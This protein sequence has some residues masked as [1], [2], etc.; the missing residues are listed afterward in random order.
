MCSS[1]VDCAIE[2]FSGKRAK[3]LVRLVE[4]SSSS[5]FKDMEKERM[6]MKTSGLHPSN[7]VK[8]QQEKQS[9]EGRFQGRKLLCAVRKARPL[10]PSRGLAK[11]FKV[12]FNTSDEGAFGRPSPFHVLSTYS[13]LKM[14]VL[15]APEK[16]LHY[17]FR[18]YAVPVLM[19]GGNIIITF[20]CLWY[21]KG[22]D[23]GPF[24]PCV[25][26]GNAFA[27]KFVGI[28]FI[29]CFLWMYIG[30]KVYGP[31]TDYGQIPEY[32]GG[33]FRFY[34]ITTASY[35][36]LHIPY[37]KLSWWFYENF[38]Q[39]VAASHWCGL[40]IAVLLFIKGK[41][42]RD[43]DEKIAPYPLIHEFYRGIELHP[44]I[45]GFDA[46]Q[47]TVARVGMTYWSIVPLSCYFVSLDKWGYNAGFTVNFILQTIYTVKFYFWEWEYM[48]QTL[49]NTLDRAGYYLCGASPISIPGLCLF[50]TFFMVAHPPLVSNFT[51]W[52]LF[53]M[54][55]V[56]IILEYQVDHQK[57]EF[58]RTDGKCLVWGKP[59]KYIEAEYETSEGKKKSKLL[60]SGYWGKVRHINYTFDITIGLCTNMVGYHYGIWPFLYNIIMGSLHIHR[61]TR[62]E[63]KCMMKYG[64][65][66]EKY[67][68]I[69][70][71]R[72][73]PGVV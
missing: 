17:I 43:Y 64:H 65:A 45:F 67:C 66:Y 56:F 42:A 14:T 26:M 2:E 48:T 10:P 70:P 21:G 30:G 33:G 41:V 23:R 28:L 15:P 60:I 44:H 46:K 16:G 47:Y 1:E 29:W 34:F 57:T 5:K 37:P 54:G 24:D 6:C 51:A 53:V 39:I 59:P 62:D 38:A 31:V 8:A 7:P 55:I 35:I 20:Y 68:R 50:S 73:I 71:Y 52:L 11:N 9:C 22:P 72:L 13:N 36:L 49:D 32:T 69:V 61:L 27:W 4:K 40:T 25:M 63:Y 58:R 12:N 3:D 18:Y 19:M